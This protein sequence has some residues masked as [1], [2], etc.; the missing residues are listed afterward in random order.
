VLANSSFNNVTLSDSSG[1]NTGITLNGGA[2]G[3]YFSL[4][5]TASPAGNNKLASGELY[6][7]WPNQPSLIVSNIPYASYDVYVYAGID[8]EGRSETVSLTPENGTAQS[9]SFTTSRGNSAWVAATST[10]DGSGNQPSLPSANYVH[11]TDLS[12]SSFTLSW[13]APGNGGLNGIQIVP[14]A[15]DP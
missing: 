15:T 6:N 7:G 8:A 14:N 3:S 5:S 2:D 12:A 13:G 9:Y 4:G 10:W 11:F 1:T